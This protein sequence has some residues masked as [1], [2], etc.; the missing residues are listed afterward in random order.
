MVCWQQYKHNEGHPG[1]LVSWNCGDLNHIRRNCPNPRSFETTILKTGMMRGF[2]DSLIVHGTIEAAS[3]DMVI[4]TGSNITILRPDVLGR[5]SKDIDI[6]V[7]PVDSLLRTVTGETTPV[8]SRGK[9]A[10]QIGTVKMIHDVWIADIENEC[11]LGLDFLISNDCVVD[12]Q[13]S[14]LRIGS[15]EVRL[16]RSRVIEEPI[17]HRVM[18]AETWLVPPKSEAIIPGVLDDDG[19]AVRGWGELN[20]TKMPGLSRDILVARWWISVSP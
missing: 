18:V 3:C 1:S 13:E 7:H 17:C 15:E 20:P 9:L 11:I 4:D 14:C 19:K 10:L 6:D 8:R 16:K 5:V 2:T 12:V